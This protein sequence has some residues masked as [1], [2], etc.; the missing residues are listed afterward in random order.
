MTNVVNIYLRDMKKIFTNIIALI[1]ILAVIIL[2]ALYAWFNIGA[3][4]DPYSNTN[5]IKVV[6][7]NDD[8][9]ALFNNKTY[10]IGD[11]IVDNLKKK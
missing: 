1:V 6:V 8:K 2:P 10:K 11:I 7:V 3:S 4:W 9:G 5:G